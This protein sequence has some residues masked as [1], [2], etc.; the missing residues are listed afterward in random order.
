MASLSEPLTI[1][2]LHRY[3]GMLRSDVSTVLRTVLLKYLRITND[4]PFEPQ[5]RLE[6]EP[7]G[8]YQEYQLGQ[9]AYRQLLAH[10][11]PVSLRS[12]AVVTDQP[13]A[14]KLNAA[15][16]QWLPW[17]SAVKR[18]PYLLLMEFTLKCVFWT[19]LT[20]VPGQTSQ[21]NPNPRL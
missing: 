8:A 15:G 7:K 13:S 18:D 10:Q 2:G 20:P 16:V 12:G 1:T 21:S 17:G 4:D 9:V 11:A 14:S 6:R 19:T 5:H 3:T